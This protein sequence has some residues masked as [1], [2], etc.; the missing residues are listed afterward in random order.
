D[1]FCSNIGRQHKSNGVYYV[2]DLKTGVFNQRHVCY[3]PDCRHFRSP[4]ICIPLHLNPFSAADMNGG[5]EIDLDGGLTDAD[6]LAIGEAVDVL[7]EM[8]GGEAGF[9]E[10]YG[11]VT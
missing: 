2:V 10:D 1:R 4:D 9:E 3:D 8:N 11:K 7:F 6:V 5:D